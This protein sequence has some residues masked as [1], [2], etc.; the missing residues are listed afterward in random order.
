MVKPRMEAYLVFD[1]SK[2]LPYLVFDPSKA[3]KP[4]TTFAYRYVFNKQV[5]L[6]WNSQSCIKK[7]QN[8]NASST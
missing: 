4:Y 8:E 6:H 1:P 7:I 5:E 2:A 3:R